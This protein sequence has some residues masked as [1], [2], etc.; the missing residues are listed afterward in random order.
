V[1]ILGDMTKPLHDADTALTPGLLS[2]WT[3]LAAAA[4]TV[5]ATGFLASQRFVSHVTGTLTSLGLDAGTWLLMLESVLLLLA[6]IA[7]SLIWALLGRSLGTPSAFALSLGGVSASVAAAGVLGALGV[8]G[9]FGGASGP[10]GELAL[11]CLLAF[12][13]GLQNASVAAATPLSLRTTHMTGPASDLGVHLGTLLVS[14][15]PARLKAGRLALVRA[16]KLLAFGAGAVVAVPLARS[17]GFGAFLFPAAVI[18]AAA[19]ICVRK[20]KERPHEDALH[21]GHGGARSPA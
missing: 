6:F 1:V 12:A 13:M 7:G 8:F 5:N 18:G 3:L 2:S 17:F 20:H 19:A 14:D 10:A 16:A 15:G 9:S 21:L 4:G 11:P